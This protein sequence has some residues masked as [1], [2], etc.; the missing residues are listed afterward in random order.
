MDNLNEEKLNLIAKHLRGE[1]SGF[2]ENL[3]KEWMNESDLNKEFYAETAFLWNAGKAPVGQIP[4]VDLAWQKVKMRTL[5][6]DAVSPS[7]DN[8][9]SFTSYS[10]Y[11]KVAASL[12][13]FVALGYLTRSL[14]MKTET[15]RLASGNHKMEFYLPDSSKVSLNK[16]STVFYSEEYNGSK[17]EVTMEGEAFFEVRKNKQKPFIVNGKFSKTEVLGTSFNV[18]S[19][20]SGTSDAIEVVTGKV[21][22]TSLKKQNS[23]VFLLPGDKAVLN[24]NGE[25]KTSKVDITNTLSWKNEKLVFENTSLQE[26]AIAMEDYFNVPVIIQN[27]ELTSCRFTGTFTK[28]SIEEMMQVL[29]VSINLSYS[30]KDQTYLLTGKGCN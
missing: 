28:P 19:Y 10:I 24:E 29:S 6:S 7:L 21:S 15:V 22:F 5:V 14:W 16:N 11:W 23:K 1:T 26:V 8:V 30:K 13:V 27:Q 3:L 18:R 4:D 25:M 9:R 2:E 12:L 20:K 17:R